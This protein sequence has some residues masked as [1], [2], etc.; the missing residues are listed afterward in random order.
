LFP[1]LS[2]INK[3]AMNKEHV[4]LLYVG[5]FLRCM[6]RSG[7]AGSSSRT[8]WYFHYH[9]LITLKTVM[10]EIWFWRWHGDQSLVN[11]YIVTTLV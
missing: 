10:L 7:I 2:I 4:S 8:I 1:A 3:A 6:P 9:E 11:F 5:A